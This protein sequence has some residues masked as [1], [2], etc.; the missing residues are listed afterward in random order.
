MLLVYVQLTYQSFIMLSIVDFKIFFIGNWQLK[1][2]F[3]ALCS[4]HGTHPNSKIFLAA[5]EANSAPT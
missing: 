1:T 3:L 4:I 5:L 2:T